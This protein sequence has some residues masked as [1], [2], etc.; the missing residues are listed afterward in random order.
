LKLT[1]IKLFVVQRDKVTHKKRKRY[2]RWPRLLDTR[3]SAK[4]CARGMVICLQQ[5]CYFH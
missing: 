4:W 5:M 3:Y 1:K 2:S